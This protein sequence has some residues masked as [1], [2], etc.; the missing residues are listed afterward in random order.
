MPG[1][2]LAALSDQVRR[3]LGLGLGEHTVTITYASVADGDTVTVHGITLTC[4]TGSAAVE[5]AQFKKETNAGAVADNLEDL[6]DA[7]FDGTTGVSSSSDS[8][9]IVTITGARSVTTDNSTGFTISSSTYQDEPPYTSDIDQFLLDGQ[10]DLANK[11]VDEALIAGNTGLS[12]KFSLIGDGSSTEIDLP[13]EFLRDRIVRAQI[14]SD[15][16]LYKLI[17]VS[18]DELFV[19][20][21]GKHSYYK[22]DSADGAQKYYAI[23]DD[24][25]YFSAAPVGGT[26]YSVA[27]A[28]AVEDDTVTVNGVVLTAKDAATTETADFITTGNDAAGAGNLNDIIGNIFGSVSGVTA[29]V[30]DNDVT[31]SGATSVTTSTNSRLALTTSTAAGAGKAIVYGIMHPQTTKGTECDLPDHI[32]P[33][34]VEYAV[35]KVYEQ[36]QRHDMAA[37]LMQ[38]YMNSIMLINQ[39]YTRRRLRNGIE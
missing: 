29:T 9:S 25:I 24:Q 5:L 6:I 37:A 34:V 15:S 3:R 14:G 33:L 36:M 12:E 28:S 38:H 39:Q 35:M 19:I 22:V 21:E 8:S 30:T 13:D 31:I 26:I 17:K 18:I 10:L 32:E 2:T 7:I 1:T 4:I 23:Y 27:F 11:C 16:A 20:R